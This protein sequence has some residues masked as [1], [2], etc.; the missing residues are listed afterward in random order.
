M[1]G[2]ATTYRKERL[3][4]VIE[5]LIFSFTSDDGTGAIASAITVGPVNGYITKVVTNPGSTAPT[6]NYGITLSDSDGCDVLGGAG[7]NRDTVNSEHLTPLVGGAY[8]PCRVDSV[9][10]FAATGNSVNDATGEVIVY[11]D[12]G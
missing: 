2:S 5:K 10:T 4:S 3:N 11:V 1:A 6:D 7:S 12:K 8:I 9:L